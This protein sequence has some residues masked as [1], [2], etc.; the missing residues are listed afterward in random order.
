MKMKNVTCFL[1]A[2]MACCF[3][4]GEIYAQDKSKQP[5]GEF[6]LNALFDQRVQKELELVPDQKDQLKEVL[7]RV[8]NRRQEYIAELQKQKNQGASEDE[9]QARQKEYVAQLEQLKKD[10]EADAL[11]ILLPH[12]RQ[13]LKQVTAQVMM[14]ESAKKKKVPT[15]L[16]TQ[17]MM[18]YLEIDEKQAGKIEE[19]VKQLQERLARQI[20]KLRD[21]ATEDLMQE[22]TA[23]QRKKYKQLMGDQ[24]DKLN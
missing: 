19:K 9:L 3:A 7:D 12:Q 21:E 5:F 1:I 8:R 14:R 17:E 10:S 18:E 24:M 15:G 16:L 23:E 6:L 2:G 4:V 20:K 13:R 11:K 22:L